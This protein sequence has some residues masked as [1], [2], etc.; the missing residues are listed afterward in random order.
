MANPEKGETSVVIAGVSYTLAM[1]FNSGVRLQALMSEGKP[2][3][4]PLSG[5]LAR[6]FKGDLLCL[7]ALF[8]SLLVE[9]QPGI[10]P[11]QAG[12]LIDHVGGI[13]AM[14][15][16][17]ERAIDASSP[18][19]QDVEELNKGNPPPAAKR[20]PRGKTSDTSGLQPG[21]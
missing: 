21:A 19:P 3:A 8:W 16:I 2:E 11:E 9:H 1:T 5:I 18:D 6:A 14:N 17:I 4:V 7:R 10:T 15:A 20:K 13:A 12:T